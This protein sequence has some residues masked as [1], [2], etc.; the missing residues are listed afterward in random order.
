MEWMI[1][2]QFIQG[3]GAACICL[4]FRVRKTG[5]LFIIPYWYM[6]LLDKTHWNNHSYLF[7]L[8]G[9]IFT[10][11]DRNVVFVGKIVILI[12]FRDGWHSLRYFLFSLPNFISQPLRVEG[13]KSASQESEEPSDSNKV[14]FNPLGLTGAEISALKVQK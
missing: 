7:G 2:L 3:I 10:L 4:G 5:W 6:F 14:N 9:L 11:T 8:M 12:H 13:L 1:L